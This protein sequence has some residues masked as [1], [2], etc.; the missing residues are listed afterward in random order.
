MASRKNF[1]PAGSWQKAHRWY[2]RSVGQ[3]GN[4]YHQRIV[5]PGA[6]RLLG[7][8]GREAASVLDL[9]CGQGVLA[10]QL[11][12][13]TEYFGFD[14]AA[15]LADLAQRRNKNSRHH[16]GVADVTQPLPL[17]KTDFSH[18]AVILALQNIENPAKALLNAQKHMR[19]SGRLVLVLNHPCFRIPRQSGW[20]ID[21]RNKLRYRRV[22]R[23][24][25]PMNI[26]L[27]I[28]PSRGQNSPVA[29]T[30]HHP[31]SAYS[32]WLRDAGFL[33]EGIE[34]W[35]SDKTSQGPAARMEN[36]SRMEIPLFLALSAR[37]DKKPQTR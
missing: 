31:L 27:Q 29:L 22:N 34:E 36:L 5:I 7:L 16:F 21:P 24:L 4:Y 33:I 11:P 12:A 3:F 13:N 10:R 26:P 8:G 1:S 30:F 6:I 14:A 32:R 15:G 35:A 23:Y 20:E 25:S 37:L 28:H 9:A 18:A 2:D 19:L 17:A